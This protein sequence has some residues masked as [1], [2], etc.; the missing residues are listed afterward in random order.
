MI[1]SRNE[2]L[3]I[4]EINSKLGPLEEKVFNLITLKSSVRDILKKLNKKQNKPYA[5]TTIMTVMD[6][7][8]KKGYLVREKNKKTFF[9][10]PN[11][12]LSDLKSRSCFQVIYKLYKNFGFLKLLFLLITIFLFNFLLFLNKR[13]FF[14]GLIKSLFNFAFLAL[15]FNTVFGLYF[16][17]FFEFTISIIND[18]QLFFNFFLLNIIYL[19]ETFSLIWFL[20]ISAIIFYLFKNLKNKYYQFFQIIYGK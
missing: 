20:I 11:V 4:F 18:P 5:Y 14:L 13:K 17:G 7:L 19:K 10:K 12:S 2:N 8:Y 1:N 15:F 6:K 9:Y 3:F 16:Q